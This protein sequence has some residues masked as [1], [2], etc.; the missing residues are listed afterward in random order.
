MGAVRGAAHTCSQSPFTGTARRGLGELQGSPAAARGQRRAGLPAPS[1]EKSG[2]HQ[3]GDSPSVRPAPGKQQSG[4][5]PPCLGVGIA[6]PQPASSALTRLVAG[7][8]HFPPL[9]LGLAALHFFKG[10]SS[11][12]SKWR[13]P[14]MAGPEP[15]LGSALLFFLPRCLGTGQKK[16]V[17]VK[18]QL[19]PK[20]RVSP[21]AGAGAK[22]RH[23]PEWGHP[24]Q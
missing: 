8:L 12:P 16:K 11:P 21:M 13:F 10:I 15:S 6:L 24:P 2:G 18:G 17:G 9:R 19:L 22:W 4:A 5:W 23:F 7:L 3:A 14:P 1:Q 20:A